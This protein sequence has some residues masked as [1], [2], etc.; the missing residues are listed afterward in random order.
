MTRSNRFVLWW[1]G[2]QGVPALGFV[3]VLALALCGQICDNI[4]ASLSGWWPCC[5]PPPS[6]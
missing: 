3:A 2:R 5:C 1:L 4:Q 6:I